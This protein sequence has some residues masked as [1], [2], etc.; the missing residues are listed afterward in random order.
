MK[1]K[2]PPYAVEPGAGRRVILLQGPSSL[3]FKDLGIALRRYGA[4]V[5]RVGYTP[6]D[7]L[8]WSRSAGAFTLCAVPV[9]EYGD[10]FAALLASE[11]PTDIVMLGDGRSYHREAI[12]QARSLAAPPNLHI[13]EHG[14]LRPGLIVVDPDGMGANSRIPER[15]RTYCCD[16]DASADCPDRPRGAGFAGYAALDVTYHLTGVL[17]GRFVNPHFVHASLDPPLRE[18]F[19]WARKAVTRPY[20]RRLQRKAE[21]RLAMPRNGPCFLFPLQLSNDFQVRQHG[22]GMSMERTLRMLLESF[23]RQAPADALLI[24]KRHPLDNGLTN[25]HGLILAWAMKLGIGERVEYLDKG[26]I[27]SLLEIVSG[28][29][30]INSTVGLTAIMA[31]KPCH[32]LGKAVYDIPGLTSGMPLERFW[33]APPA[34]D[35]NLAR[36]FRS[37]L[38]E[39]YHIPGCFDGP[40][41][42]IGA[43][44]LAERI[45]RGPE[46]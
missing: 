29:V 14:Y 10:W 41:S 28:V 9:A 43:E 13:V 39:N 31:G 35:A 45:C 18:Y 30:T 1:A 23:A 8:F 12:L 19:G 4:N 24:I 16:K 17:L 27:E 33:S 15:F 38:L 11:Q 25:W 22:C 20:R 37:F 34:P 26:S 6:G 44:R 32:V 46:P 42:K 2:H 7:R 36:K 3:F 40:G 5:L 21:A